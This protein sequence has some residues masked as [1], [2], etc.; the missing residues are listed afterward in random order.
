MEK[1]IV[2]ITEINIENILTI[3]NFKDESDKQTALN[4]ITEHEKNMGKT[5]LLKWRGGR[6]PRGTAVW[7]KKISW[8]QD[9]VVSDNEY[10]KIGTYIRLIQFG[11]E[12]RRNHEI[13]VFLDK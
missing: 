11:G 12:S 6:V 9:G 8:T 10:K 13:L 1:Y 7:D 3:C 4:R 5:F 2:D